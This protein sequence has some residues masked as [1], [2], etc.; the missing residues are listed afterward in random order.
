VDLPKGWQD[1]PAAERE[2]LRSIGRAISEASKDLR[3]GEV[4]P[5]LLKKIGMT[6]GEFAAFVEKYRDVFGES[7]DMPDRT[8]RPTDVVRGGFTLPGS[9][10]LQAGKGTGKDIEGGSGT[11]KLTPDELRKLYESRAA[12][13]SPEYRKQV[14]AYF[15]AISEAAGRAE[16]PAPTTQPSK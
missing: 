9:G 7:A 1:L 12:K 10:R 13:V 2:R 11:E 6:K 16:T 3:A 5:A 4:D 15:R 14:E 8:E